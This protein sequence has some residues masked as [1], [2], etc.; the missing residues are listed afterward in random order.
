MW[1]RC[2]GSGRTPYQVSVDLVAP[3]WR[4]TCP[5]RKVPCKHALALL[6]LWSQ[7]A[8]EPGGTLAGGDEVADFAVGWSARRSARESVATPGRTPD[9]QAQ[10]ARLQRRLQLMDAGV[11]ELALWLGDLARTGLGAARARPGSW[12]DQ[13]GARLVDA[14]LPGLAQTVRDLGSDVVSREDWSEHLLAVTGRLWAVVRAWRRRTDLDADQLGDLRT[15]V[16]WPVPRDEVRAGPATADDWLVLGTH[17]S[18]D[19]RLQQQ[20]TWLHGRRTGE[21]VQLLDF[22]A[23]GAGLPLPQTTGASLTATLACYPGHRPRRGLLL[24]EPRPADTPVPWPT[25]RTL[26]EALQQR[27]DLLV[28]QPW[29]TVCL[30]HLA[31]VALRTDPPARLVDREGWSL[32][33]TGDADVWSLAARTGGHPVDLVAE[34]TGAAL[35]PLTVTGAPAVT[36]LPAG[37]AVVV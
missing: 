18:D 14:Q 21:T 13:A 1:G 28:H 24:D 30:V 2:Q 9:P 5:S 10:A 22:A 20:R 7:G 4:C 27:A 33:L 17:R 6:L 19:G 37:A 3:A 26:A 34:L 23:G 8:L 25:P 12:W 11:E 36:G 31:G 15:V 35:R 32:P 16:G 29:L